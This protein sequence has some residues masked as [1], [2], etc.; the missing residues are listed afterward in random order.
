MVL[1]LHRQRAATAVIDQVL[2]AFA[3]LSPSSIESKRTGMT[4]SSPSFKLPNCQ[5]IFAGAEKVTDAI[6]IHG[7][8]NAAELEAID[9]LTPAQSAWALAN[10]FNGRAKTHIVLPGSDGAPAAVL[11]GLGGAATGEPCGPADLLLGELPGKLPSATYVLGANWSD[12][13]LAC[14][15]WGLGSYRFRR[16]KSTSSTKQPRLALG[17][18]LDADKILRTTAA[19]WLGRDLINTP[20]N[21]MGPDALEAA[22][23]LVAE[24]H[25]A[26]CVVITGDDLIT[27]NFPLI[28]AVGRASTE[29]RAPRLVDISWGAAD[30]PRV[31]I[32]GK[33]VCFDTGGLDLKQ[34]AG[35]LLM[36]KD[37]GGAAAALTLGDMVMGAKLNIR[38]RVLIPA[39]ENSVS[40]EAFRPG[41]IIPSRA[42]HSVEIG[43]TDAEGRLVLADALSLGDED[44]PEL[45]MTFA[46][47]T[48]AA[49]VALGPDLPPFFVDDD[50][51]AQA[52]TDAGLTVGDP[53]WRLPFWPGYDRMLES[54]SADISNTGDS[55]FAGA[56]TAA[57]FLKRFVKNAKHYAHFDIY[58]WR[59]VQRPLGP[60]GGEPH[61][62]RTMFDVIVQI[63]EKG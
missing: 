62:A 42:G 20:A 28:H 4:A 49:R 48:G 26:Q 13:E 58:G 25:S 54:S 30:A 16:Y 59:P 23:L 17:S 1:K 47:L 44:T 19:I 22:A 36:K 46:T 3:I 5:S 57:L 11:F 8:H 14:I 43:N 24:R 55:P 61:A 40:A 7:V 29:R 60:K 34:A 35:M 21:D 33:G 9:G 38:L 52:I 37:M 18:A 32:V 12:G 39:V 50:T 10:N 15:A 6:P 41:D 31:T 56:V 53:V 45:M 2:P 63:A 27:Q 51:M